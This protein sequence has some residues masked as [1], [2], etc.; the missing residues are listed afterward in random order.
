M[1][2][3]LRD[4]IRLGSVLLLAIPCII[5]GVGLI[6]AQIF[7]EKKVGNIRLNNIKEK[8]Y[9]VISLCKMPS[10]MGRHIRKK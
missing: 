2:D 7:F 1:N 3:K 8:L 6:F 5:L 4:I 9:A 10:R